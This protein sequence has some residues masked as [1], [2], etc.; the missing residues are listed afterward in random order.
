M[1][2]NTLPYYDTLILK[3]FGRK[4]TVVGEYRS[5]HI[6]SKKSVDKYKEVYP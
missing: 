2:P 5:I 6:I 1:N 3:P 4:K